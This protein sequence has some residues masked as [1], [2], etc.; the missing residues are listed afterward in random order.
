MLAWKIQ[1]CVSGRYYKSSL[2]NMKSLILTS[3]EYGKGGENFPK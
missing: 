2:F 3:K 1:T